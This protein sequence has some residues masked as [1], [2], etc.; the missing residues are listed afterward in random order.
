LAEIIG[1]QYKKNDK[2]YDFDPGGVKYEI[3]TKVI[4][5]TVFGLTMGEVAFSNRLK[6]DSKIVQPLKKVVR[7]ATP[8]DMEQLKLNREREKEAAEVWDVKIVEHELDMKLIDV[9]SSFDGGKIV[10]SFTAEGR[11]DFRNLVKDLATALKAR[12]QL[13]Q[14]GPRDEAKLLGGLGVCGKVI[15]C[16]SSFMNEFQTISIKMAK[17]QRLPLN[18]EKISGICGKLMCCLKFEQEAYEELSKITPKIDAVV[19]TPA[20][21][22]IVIDVNILSG[23]LKIRINNAP[24]AAPK[25]YHR[26]EV[27]VIR[28]S[29]VKLDKKEIE[30]LAGLEDK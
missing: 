29:E 18:P 1:V 4:V 22:G 23:I 10:F 25:Q 14:I 3:G 5:D 7:T 12:I 6:D 8:Q 13:R 17:E 28:D 16:N 24:E 19:S 15:C 26:S 30:T 21:N 2:I 9:E 11:V 27:R 20:G